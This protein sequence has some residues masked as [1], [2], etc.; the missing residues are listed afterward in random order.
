M[1]QKRTKS[2]YRVEEV[3]SYFSVSR[4]TIRRL[5]E[6]EK[7]QA[8]KIRGC[9]RI[10]TEEISRYEQAILTADALEYKIS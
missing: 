7:L 2:Y 4:R 10:S 9:L 3:A 5:V 1:T 6:E 8:T